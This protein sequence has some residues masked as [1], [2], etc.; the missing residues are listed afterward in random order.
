MNERQYYKSI[1]VIEWFSKEN[2]G[3]YLNWQLPDKGGEKIL[4]RLTPYKEIPTVEWKPI[5]G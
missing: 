5:K 2:D 1:T 4:H 3:V